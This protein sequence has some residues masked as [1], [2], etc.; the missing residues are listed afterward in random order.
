MKYIEWRQY[1]KLDGLKYIC[2]ENTWSHSTIILSKRSTYNKLGTPI[3]LVNDLSDSS[4]AN[5]GKTYNTRNEAWSSGINKSK[6]H[7]LT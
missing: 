6:D 5:V 1:R 3:P 4:A 7:L 2:K